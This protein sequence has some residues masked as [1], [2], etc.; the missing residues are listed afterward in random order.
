MGLHEPIA[1]SRYHTRPPASLGTTEVVQEHLDHPFGLALAH[2][3]MTENRVTPWYR[4]T[5]A[6][7]WNRI[8]Q[9]KAL[10]QGRSATEQPANPRARIVK[11]LSVAM[12]Y[13]A[14]LYRRL[15]T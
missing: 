2:D 9:V 7:D 14:D 11:A 1:R 15:P 12:M 6:I 5:I 13:N 4:D 8:A 3:S 10:I